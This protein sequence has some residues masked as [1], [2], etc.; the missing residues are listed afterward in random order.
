MKNVVTKW[1][2]FVILGI[3]IASAI[4]VWDYTSHGL[5]EGVVVWKGLYQSNFE[6][7]LFRPCEGNEW[8]SNEPWWWAEGNLEELFAVTDDH[9]DLMTPVYVEFT[10][11]VSRKGSY[12]NLGVSERKI[13]INKVI[14]VQQ[15]IPEECR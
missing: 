2:G 11:K 1:A 4:V 8:S 12:G 7:S 5:R 14:K 15:E 3:V 10:G 9:N 13:T 6:W